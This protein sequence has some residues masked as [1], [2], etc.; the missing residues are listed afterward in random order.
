MSMTD[1]PIVPSKI[2]NVLSLSPTV[3]LP[4]LML[5]PVFASMIEPSVVSAASRVMPDLRTPSCATRQGPS[6]VGSR[7]PLERWDQ[8]PEYVG[9]PAG[10]AAF[11]VAESSVHCK[12]AQSTE[13]A[14][15]RNYVAAPVR[16]VS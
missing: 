4:V 2:G 11:C 8:L 13:G 15:F 12:M 1:G 3:N 7:S 16:P 6:C 5:A 14:M 9:K 10:E